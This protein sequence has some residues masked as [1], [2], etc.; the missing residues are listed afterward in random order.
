MAKVIRLPKNTKG[1]DFVVGDIHGC[2][3]LLEKALEKIN[4]DP[5]KDRLLSV[6]DLINRGPESHRATEFLRKS[7]FYAVRGNHEE[8][9]IGKFSKTGNLKRGYPKQTEAGRNYQWQ[10]Q[11]SKKARA[12]L[13]RAFK[14]LPFAIEVETDIG[15]VGIVHA[16]VSADRW[17]SFISKLNDGCEQTA[18]RAMNERGRLNRNVS[19]EIK[20]ISRVFFGHSYPRQGVTA[21]SNCVYIDTGA[22]ISQNRRPSL[23]RGYM[24]VIEITA[25]MAMIT[26][27]PKSPTRVNTVTLQDGLLKGRKIA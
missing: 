26:Q 5:S 13:R 23:D 8:Y 7:W 12:R 14:E 16:E 25:P 6:G 3:S 21:L 19:K 1:R 22:H 17:Q 27:N 18:R 4:F 20:G 11:Q 9:F 15:P 24:S 2:F 10:Y